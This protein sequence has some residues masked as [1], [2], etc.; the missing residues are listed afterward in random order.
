[1]SAN[2]NIYEKSRCYSP[3]NTEQDQT[4]EEEFMAKDIEYDHEHS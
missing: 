4:I 3:L 2:E 1:M